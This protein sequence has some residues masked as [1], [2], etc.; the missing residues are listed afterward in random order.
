VERLR[1][2]VVGHLDLVRKL[3]PSEESVSTPRA[4]DAAHRALEVIADHGAILDLNTAGWRKGLGRPYVAPWLLER[5]RQL[6]VPVCFG[7][8]SHGPHQVGEGIEE[9]RRYLLENDVE[10]ITA[11]TKRD[12]VVVREI[13]PLR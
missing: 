2:D 3:A 12:G 5:V 9:S 4:R 13:V 1:P 10:T 11:I 7:V 8:D 6:G